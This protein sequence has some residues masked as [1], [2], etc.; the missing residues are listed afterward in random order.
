MEENR[1]NI[2]VEQYSQSIIAMQ[3]LEDIK[4]IAD[5]WRIGIRLGDLD[6]NG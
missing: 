4:K 6:E 5:A 2:S 1:I 3:K